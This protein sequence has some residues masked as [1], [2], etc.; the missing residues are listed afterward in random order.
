M[1]KLLCLIL[2]MCLACPFGLSIALAEE[3]QAAATETVLFAYDFE[4]G[5]TVGANVPTKSDTVN[6]WTS[7]VESTTSK[8]KVYEDATQGKVAQYS[9][10]ATSN[11]GPRLQKSLY[12]DD[13]VTNMTVNYKFRTENASLSFHLVFADSSS[14][15]FLSAKSS[16]WSTAKIVLNFETDTY[17]SYVN[18][19]LQQSGAI[20]FSDISALS[21]RFSTSVI[22]GRYAYLD[23][24]SV[25]TTSTVDLEACNSLSVGLRT[26]EEI[27]AP[28]A[29]YPHAPAISVPTGK[30]ELFNYDCS[31]NANNGVS[32]G[33]DA[34]WTGREDVEPDILNADSTN[35]G[36]LI[37]MTNDTR[38][39]KKAY[40]SKKLAV[41]T[42]VKEITSEHYSVLSNSAVYF[43]LRDKDGN[44]L[45]D[46]ESYPISE[47]STGAAADSWNKVKAVFDVENSLFDVYVNDTAVAENIAF[48]AALPAGTY[49]AYVYVYGKLAGAD[50]I[51]FDNFV[52]YQDAAP[53]MDSVKYYGTTGTTWSLVANDVVLG[54]DSLVNNLRQHPRIMVTS[55]QDLLNKIA[56][57]PRTAHWYKSVKASADATLTQ[58]PYA[59]NYGNGRNILSVARGI[60]TRLWNLSMAYLVEQD[61][62]YVLRAIEEM[63]NAATFP[64]WS[65]NAP[66]IPS[67][68]ML[69]FAGFYDWCYNSPVM[70]DEVKAEMVQ[71]VKDQALWQFVRSY[72]GVISVEIARGSSNRTTV[73]NS[74]AGL[75]AIAVADEY[76]Q[77]SQF[78][79]DNALECMKKP[80]NAYGS[81][82]AY[83]EGA[84]YWSYPMRTITP[85]MSALQTAPADGY[86]LPENAQWY[87]DH[88]AL[89]NT[90]DYWAY[91]SGAT[92]NFDFG[93]ASPGLSA[94]SAIYW[95]AQRTNNPF[96]GWYAD[97]ILA[98]TGSNP[99][100]TFFAIPWIDPAFET[101][102]DGT[103]PLDKTFNAADNAQ[104]A[105]M[106]SSWSADDALYAAM[107]GGYNGTGHMFKSLGTF[108]IDANGERFVRTIGRSDYS[109]LYPAYMYYNE[110]A[111]GQNTL[112][113]N[114]GEGFDQKTTAYGRFTRHDENE[115]EAFTV[116]DMTETNDDFTSATRGMYMT[117]GRRSVVIQDEA[118]MDF[119]SEVWWFAHT[120]AE[121]VIA[122]DGKSAM[123]Y[124]NGERMY[125]CISSGPADAVFTAMEARPLP[126]SPV[127]P[128]ENYRSFGKLAIHAKDVSEMTL[129]VEFIPLKAGEAA[130]SAVTPV[131]PIAEW[132]LSEDKISTNRQAGYSLVFMN[133]SP[134]A[135]KLEEKVLINEEDTSVAPFK[136]NGVYY[137]PAKFAIDGFFA[138][139]SL[140]EAKVSVTRDYVTTNITENIITKNGTIFVPAAA[141]AEALGVKLYTDD[142]GLIALIDA[143]IEYSEETKAALRK[144]LGTRVLVANKDFI[145]FDIDKTNYELRY[146]E[147]VPVVKL[148]DGT[149]VT[150]NGNTSTFV[151]DGTT[152]T[153]TF[154]KDRFKN[155]IHNFL[156]GIV[157]TASLTMGNSH[158]IGNITNGVINSGTSGA[159]AT[160]GTTS[161]QNLTFTFEFDSPYLIDFIRIIDQ[162]TSAGST[163]DKATWEAQKTDGTW[164]QLGVHESLDAGTIQGNGRTNEL[165]VADGVEYKGLRVTLENTDDYTQ[166]YFI[167]ELQAFGFRPADDGV[168][169]TVTGVTENGENL[170]FTTELVNIDYSG[171]VVVALYKDGKQV[172]MKIQPYT[173]ETS[174]TYTLPKVDYDEAKVMVIESF[175][176]MRILADPEIL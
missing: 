21:L 146:E 136:E 33:T 168:P 65:N 67:E 14:Q 99:G 13:S 106:R 51:L 165:I 101:Y 70:T 167:Y 6:M 89:K 121:M 153:I 174:V 163:L 88:V 34:L 143:P 7:R 61:D 35:N 93:D 90:N 82:G 166:R 161:V 78:L 48:T 44:V 79:L 71:I 107:Q 129:T 5:T 97:H 98:K 157:P 8:I 56:A 42:A 77:L 43:Q 100:E 145:G 130:P 57:D 164:V 147:R 66:I 83:P 138:T 86:A 103:M 132:A 150:K 155:A 69:G 172:G 126:T 62:A 4:T 131:T 29:A 81:D 115:N 31:L 38:A 23:D 123:L 109:A 53:V 140:S 63:R 60:G 40:L 102:N 141:M 72:D 159:A 151:I 24:V 15:G 41:G 118:V 95:H 104:I 59:Y 32:G 87:F 142:S 122:E 80:T 134:N 64:D 124:L 9:N 128:D 36:K 39:T 49:E 171:Y 74:A 2:C 127:A 137:V 1:K 50:T 94:T 55:R 156:L 125:V 85:F 169:Y 19:T 176:N 75:F 110:R 25:T 154:V 52:M 108:V 30:Y 10:T 11:G 120:D 27:M 133:G 158:V 116:L 76:P 91:V 92:A 162:R 16:G 45:A 160:M 105:S 139:G 68:I 47:K 84:S 114:P 17:A 144:Q 113:I 117:P 46:T 173:D 73:A 3:V 20:K 54:E 18:G 149:P 26:P 175:V 12:L 148:K 170:T 112:I 22:N 28:F 37:R 119:P 111:E 58:A 96:Y 152:Y 135:L